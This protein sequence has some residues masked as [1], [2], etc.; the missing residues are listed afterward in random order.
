VREGSSFRL[1]APFSSAWSIEQINATGDGEFLCGRVHYWIIPAKYMVADRHI[2]AEC[3]LGAEF[4][5]HSPRLGDRPDEPQLMA[6]RGS[7]LWN[8]GRLLLG[9]R[10]VGLLYKAILATTALKKSMQR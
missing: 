5:Q 2:D 9:W 8:P 6:I 10:P 1:K 4:Y 3:N 7:C